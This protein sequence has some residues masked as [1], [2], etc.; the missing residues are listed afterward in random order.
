MIFVVVILVLMAHWV[1]AMILPLVLGGWLAA[2]G[3]SPRRS[4]SAFPAEGPVDTQLSSAESAATLAACALDRAR[5]AQARAENEYRSASTALAPYWHARVA[6]AQREAGILQEAVAALADQAEIAVDRAEGPRPVPDADGCDLRPDPLSARTLADLV[7]RLR[8]YRAWAGQPSLR[9]IAGRAGSVGQAVSHTT[10]HNVLS[11]GAAPGLPVVVAIIAGCG[12]NRK[13]QR[14][15][16]TAW[17][18]ITMG[19]L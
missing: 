8:D 10:V 1:P 11:G 14:D 13:D 18:R 7:D 16:A 12:G 3:L 5:E 4:R 15:F 19:H 2:A 9:R 6:A 17:R